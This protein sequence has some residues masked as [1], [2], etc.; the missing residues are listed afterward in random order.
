M[1][2]AFNK[3]LAEILGK[4]DEKVLEAKLNAAMDMLKK[5]N[6]EELVKKINKMDKDELIKKMNEFDMSKLQDLNI[7]KEEIKK[8]VNDADLNNIAKMLGDQ[9]DE[10]INKIKDILNN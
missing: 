3:K 10:I 7:D 5:G 1:N 2:N 6:T 8:R 4:M 9:G